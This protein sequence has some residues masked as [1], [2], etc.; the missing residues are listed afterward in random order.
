MA[1]TGLGKTVAVPVHL[2]LRLS[3]R[4]FT[5]R[6]PNTLQ[7]EYP[8]VWVVEPRIPIALDEAAHLNAL[9]CQFLA[10][11]G[12]GPA[13]LFGAI[14]SVG[15][16]VSPE[17]PIQFITTGVLSLLVDEG[18][19]VTGRDRVII[20][21][22]HVT[23]EQSGEMELAI[24]ECWKLG[25]VVDY[26][27]ATVNTTGLKRILN[28]SNIITADQQRFPIWLHNLGFSLEEVVVD[29]VEKTLV[30]PDPKSSYFPPKSYG[31]YREV[32]A[33]VLGG[34]RR[35][36]GM[37][38]VVNSFEGEQSDVNRIARLIETAPYNQ[39]YRRVHVVRLASAVLRDPIRRRAFEQRLARIEAQ[40]ENY[41][42]VATSVVEMG[43]TRETLDFIA[44]MDSGF[45][46]EDVGGLLLP[47][48]VP[49]GVNALRQRI[50]RVGRK[51][52]G[53]A[54]ISREV[55][56][57]YADWNDERLNNGGFQYESIRMPLATN[58]LS[59][60]AFHSFAREWDDP[61]AEL[62]G[63]N[64]PSKIHLDSKRINAFFAE[65]KRLTELGIA[66]GR[67]LTG[68]G[69]WCRGWLGMGHLP[70][71]YELQQSLA[72]QS[73]EQVCF[74]L[75]MVALSDTGLSDLLPMGGAFINNHPDEDIVDDRMWVAKSF[76][77]GV[78]RTRGGVIQM[79]QIINSAFGHLKGV[80]LDVDFSDDFE[81]V[82]WVFKEAILLDSQSEPLAL[83]R[84]LRYFVNQH[85]ATLFGSVSELEYELQMNELEREAEMFGLDGRR[86]LGALRALNRALVH[87]QKVNRGRSLLQ[88]IFGTTRMVT[89]EQ[90]QLPEL[91][92]DA[93]EQV[94]QIFDELS[95]RRSIV[96]SLP[97][98]ASGEDPQ[99][100][101]LY[102]WFAEEGTPE[103]GLIGQGQ[104]TVALEDGLY[105]SARILPQRSRA[106]LD[107]TNRWR[108]L[109]QQVDPD[110]EDASE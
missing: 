51:R 81:A 100:G 5:G 59:G 66:Q 94:M 87:F 17:A 54:F 108:L 76:E 36:H 104:T 31:H 60:L 11:K 8:H 61:V 73:L 74:W 95:E 6:T 4:F 28:I 19:L 84:I 38:I 14:T 34:R 90:L 24:S 45:E 56:A 93:E 18:K 46:N 49:L 9:F 20:D 2:F 1:A 40:Q 10:T 62:A 57:H 98:N 58:P 23:I 65:R 69:K 78:I 55:G 83:Y 3:E 26:M 53:I 30:N 50:G 96:V 85:G 72:D 105:I 22:A 44:T 91:S 107:D 80:T 41:V 16:A 21:E 99:P 33:G 103:R 43:I 109:H 48:E 42:L 63:L 77:G 79:A 75:V 25:V 35:S 64:L 86:V 110:E 82:F 47:H 13:V 39:P 32:M 97:E 70:Y 27:S 67:A 68:I 89:L 92:D 15:G 71:A 101:E 7:D 52:G 106:L 12:E 88:K 29:L 37:L 102:M